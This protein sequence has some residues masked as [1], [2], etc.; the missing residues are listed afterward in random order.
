MAEAKGDAPPEQLGFRVVL[1]ETM[2]VA[3]TKEP[4]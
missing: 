3:E 2:L 1:G 4:K